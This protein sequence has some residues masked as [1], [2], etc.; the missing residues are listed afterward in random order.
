M[1]YSSAELFTWW[2]SSPSYLLFFAPYLH[3]YRQ[4]IDDT[5]VAV[6]YGSPGEIHE[7][8]FT[9]SGKAPNITV[10]EGNA[11]LDKRI[12][13]DTAIL[14]YNSTGQ[15]VVSIGPDIKLY[16]LDKFEAYKL[17]VPALS[18]GGEGNVIVKGPYLVRNACI[19]GST[20]HVSGDTN[21][22]VPVEVIASSKVSSVKW[23]DEEISTTR[24]ATGS[25]VGLI[26]FASPEVDIPVLSELEWV[27]SSF[28]D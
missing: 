21:S 10:L 20:L 2:A 24:S 23:N 28:R 12:S 6:L 14:N 25:L 22:T 4:K 7:T 3:P 9:F 18:C 5:Y 8:A 26:K 13:N 27:R 16:L 17:W 11:L 15:S 1:L 19:I